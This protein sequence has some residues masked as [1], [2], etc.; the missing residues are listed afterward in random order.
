MEGMN[1]FD[2][3][4]I[5]QGMMISPVYTRY[6]IDPSW[7]AKLSGT[8]G[9]V[10]FDVL[11]ANDEAPG[12]TWDSG[13]NP[14]EGMDAFWGIARFKYSLR[15]DN[16]L[17]ILY[18]GRHFAGGKNNVLGADL[19]YRLFKNAR[20]TVSYLHSGTNEPGKDQVKIGNGVN[21]MVQYTT[22][23]LFLW[24]SYERYDEDFTMY[25][26]FLN[27][28][29]MSRKR[30]LFAPNF[31]MKIKGLSWLRKIQPFLQYSM[32]HDFGTQMDERYWEWGVNMFFTRSGYLKIEFRNEKEAWL[33]QH[34]NKNYFFTFG[35]IQ[36]SK[37]L[38]TEGYIRYGDQ[39]YYHPEEPFLG[40]ERDI[41]LRFILQ[42]NIKLKLDFEWI[43][44]KLNKKVDEIN[45]NIF[46]VNIINL[47]TTYQFSRFFFIR[48]ALRYN[49][50][51]YQKKLFTDFLASFTLIP[52]TVIHLGYGSLYEKKEWQ[53][54]RW[55]PGHGSLLNTKNSLFFKVSY[56]WRI[57]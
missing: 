10:L 47:L 50:N 52:G 45:Q 13:A 33:G 4:L 12:Y 38:Y 17:G 3:G 8:S 2:F 44:N 26:A 42:P 19:Q 54:N 31:Y 41:I 30:I 37:W 27:R 25:S 20:F 28:I 57:K 56:L 51:D 6:I 43:H 11:A 23:K 1:A 55:V 40:T 36:L 53:D 7:A 5:Y 14:Y 16:S 24:A 46:T 39:I 49:D 22:R 9:K 21:A 48:G 32:L 29:N 34:F 18:S 35:R 15:S